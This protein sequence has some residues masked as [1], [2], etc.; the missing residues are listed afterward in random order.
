[1]EN[2]KLRYY[3]EFTERI[4]M[5]MEKIRDII[6]SIQNQE[7][8]LRDCYSEEFKLAKKSDFIEMILL[9]AVFIIEFMKEY[10]NNDEGPNRFEPRTIL[11]IR[12]DLI[13]LENQ[14]PFF[15]IQEIY[16]E[17]NRARQD[18]T[19]IPFFDLVTSHSKNYKFLKK[20]ETNRSVRKSR[21][22]TDLLRNFM[23]NGAR[24][25]NGARK[26]NGSSNPIMLRHNAV[27]LRAAGVEFEV[28]EDKCLLNITFEKGV[29]KIPLLEVDYHFERAVRNIMALEQCLYQNEA[30][31]CS[32]IKFMDHLIDSAEDVGLLVGKKIITHRLGNDAAVSVMINK[33]CE[34]ISDPYTYYDDICEKMNDHCDS[35]L[36]RMKATLELVYFP[37]VW[38]GTG[39]I[40]AAVLLMLT[41]I[42]TITSVKSVF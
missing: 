17:Y 9:D 29:L 37:H 6:R 20:V 3:K 23:L 4:G 40:A 33:L 28:A 12:E 13:L 11:D 8:R 30:Y 16:D 15:I 24:Q 14:L 10:S 35:L 7:E 31:V 18:P 34:N 27:K 36:N 38:R 5:D 1:M 25:P 19:A 32:Y 39:T 22:F 21:H 26:L 41:L 42:Q 2:E